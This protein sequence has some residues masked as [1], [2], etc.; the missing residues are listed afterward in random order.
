MCLCCAD[1]GKFN[2]FFVNYYVNS[3]FWQFP[4]KF[5]FKCYF[6][7]SLRTPYEITKTW[8]NTRFV[9]CQVLFIILGLVSRYWSSNSPCAKH[10]ENLML[11]QAWIDTVFKSL[12]CDTVLWEASFCFPS[13]VVVICITFTRGFIVKLSDKMWVKNWVIADTHSKSTES[14][15]SSFEWQSGSRTCT[16]LFKPL[17]IYSTNPWRRSSPHP[18]GS[19]A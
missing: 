11:S 5:T 8:Q 10:K 15:S 3:L 2:L 4:N 19:P 13:I 18:P 7:F 14:F 1:T 9:T 16:W 12:S 6:I 17:K